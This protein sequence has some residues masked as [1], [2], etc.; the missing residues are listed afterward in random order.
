[1]KLLLM[2]FA[3]SVLVLA[4]GRVYNTA[5]FSAFR[6]ISRNSSLVNSGSDLSSADAQIEAAA[7]K[8]NIADTTTAKNFLNIVLFAAPVSMRSSPQPF[9]AVE[10]TL[11]FEEYVDND[12][13][14]V[15]QDP[16]CRVVSFDARRFHAVL[17]H[18]LL[19]L[20]RNTAKMR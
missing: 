19:D 6:S 17:L 7:V 16:A 1:M 11:F 9:E 10:L 5:A 8:S 14:K 18:F 13:Y 2:N 4:S 20:V 3:N 15:E 12:V